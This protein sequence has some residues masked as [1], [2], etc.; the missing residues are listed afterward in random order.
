MVIYTGTMKYKINNAR[1][2]VLDDFPYVFGIVEI[3]FELKTAAYKR[4]KSYFVWL[5]FYVKSFFI[6]LCLRLCM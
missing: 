3:C 4:M 1:T 2:I 6:L 5:F